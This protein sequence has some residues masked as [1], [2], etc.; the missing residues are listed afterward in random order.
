VIWQ[1]NALFNSTQASHFCRLKLLTFC[2]HEPN[3][4]VN[5]CNCSTYELVWWILIGSRDKPWPRQRYIQK[6]KRWNRSENLFMLLL[7]LSC[8]NFDNILKNIN[9]FTFLYT[10]LFES[11]M[12]IVILRIWKRQQKSSDWNDHIALPLTGD[13]RWNDL[14]HCVPKVTQSKA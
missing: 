13:R 12:T 9:K 8:T 7:W 5:P 11:Q 3:F 2:V 10:C 1:Q 6:T 4:H 14:L